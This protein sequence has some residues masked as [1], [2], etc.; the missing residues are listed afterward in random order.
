LSPTP[1]NKMQFLSYKIT[2][3]DVKRL[4]KLI[5]AVDKKIKKLDFPD[6]SEYK[7]TIDGII[8]FENDLIDGNI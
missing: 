2:N 5:V 6:I 4:K 1:Q 3:E 7:Q 8:S